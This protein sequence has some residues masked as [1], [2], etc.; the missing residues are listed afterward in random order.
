MNKSNK[1]YKR[2]I[3]LLLLI[4]IVAG[5]CNLSFAT[6]N[7]IYIDSQE[8]WVKFSQDASLDTYF[9]DKIVILRTNLELSGLEKAQVP[10][11]AGVFDGKDHEIS[12]V[13]ITESGSNQGLFRYLQED[14]VIKNLRISGEIKPSGSKGIVG[15]LVGNNKGSI[16]HCHFSGTVKGDSNIG[17]LVGIN[18]A[19]GT[20]S[21]ATVK[22]SVTGNHFTGGIVGQNLGTI[23]KS[24]NAAEINTAIADSVV[25]VEGVNWAK[26]NS[27]ENISA[28]TD[29]G[30][31]TGYSSGYIQDCIN[32][33]PVG[34]TYMGYN[35]GGV[36]GR[37]SGYLSNCQNY[38]TV[39][40]RKDVGG[41]VGQIEPHLM[42]TFSEDTL[43]K[44]NREL[45]VLQNILNN[46]FSHAD[47]SSQT[48]SLGLRG[49]GESIDDTRA[50]SQTLSKEAADYL[51]EV[52]DT[53]NITSRRVR[54]TL[55]EIIPILNH[56]PELSAFLNEGLD[57]IE[58]GF[59]NLEMTSNKMA[60]GLDISQDAMKN[61]RKAIT[62]GED[63]LYKIERALQNL[64]STLEDTKNINKVIG[65]IEGGIDDL[66]N[67]FQSAGQAIIDITTALKELDNLD[68]GFTNMGSELNDLAD[69]LG[70]VSQI[71]SKT[72]NNIETIINKGI[73][74]VT[75]VIK[76]DLDDIFYDFK[77]ATGRLAHTVKD[78]EETFSKLEEASDQSGKAFSNFSDGFNKFGDSS[79]KMTTM[80]IATRDLI[81][82]LV[83]EPS[84]ELP[85]ISS[86]YRQSGEALFDSLGNM[87]TQI[88]DLH[89]EATNAKDNIISDMEAASDQVIVIFNSLIDARE[90]KED[91]GY[92]EDISDETIETAKQGI[93]YNNHN[94]GSVSGSSN[95][96]GIAGAMAIEYDLDPEDDI[97]KTG[98]PS[99]NFKYL[100]TAIVKGSINK[101]KI[102]AKK[103]H[104]GG[105]V[106]RMDIGIITGCENYGDIESKEGDYIGGIAGASH[107]RIDKSFALSILSGK[108]YVG[109]VSGYGNNISNSYSL[110]KITKG[111]EY[112]GSI[113]GKAEGDISNNHYVQGEIAAIDGIS[114]SHK[115]CPVSYEQ[116]LEIEGLP[117]AF[118]QFHLTFIADGNIIKEIPFNYGDSFDPSLLPKIPSK[119]EHDS[120]WEQFNQT[121]MVFNQTIEAIYTPLRTVLSS[122]VVGGNEGLPLLLAE[123]RF[124]KD[125]ALKISSVDTKED[126]VLGIW[127]VA[128]EGLEASNMNTTLRFLMPETKKKIE[129]WEAV[130]GGWE[131]VDYQ[132]NGSYMVFSI[133]G[134]ISTFKITEKNFSWTMVFLVFISIIIG[135]GIKMFS[136]RY[137][138]IPSNR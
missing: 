38:N 33:G 49:V 136:L 41:I 29:T 51:D 72:G 115:A 48:L 68:P 9:K 76:S 84:I 133:S 74:E 32:R 21:N 131:K 79:E 135:L 88:K 108:D 77:R 80:V 97:F 26:I 63:A 4:M 46:S 98:T 55:E 56:G 102:T 50:I 67:S 10:T 119:N 93:I 87:S 24:T 103:D 37:Q 100:T 104:V 129:V 22:G 69:A 117:E 105:I 128:L 109:G 121:S 62:S 14:A 111:T 81:D 91:T 96:G 35:V 6:S 99:L 31:I 73:S 13:T 16:E 107:T 34:Y 18:E 82:S 12:G 90:D 75:G 65:E 43:Q 58:L 23:L 66:G 71:I 64:L 92:I 127:D 60:Q 3:T 130:D 106:G 122:D 8:D 95:I 113:A 19:T 134:D 17:G 125:V 54:Y 114:Y 89:G 70:S 124:N 44:L 27:T 20:I 86:D 85:N 53:V 138:K 52:T 57:H 1:I 5:N 36:V 2:F 110:V 25:N 83:S 28:H 116:L 101:G 123:G 7:T 120:Q 59:D 30:G 45:T 118:T 40:G 137:K 15:G 39:L 126:G 61:L 78:L 11:F 112:I 47:A 132:I 42:L 94:Y